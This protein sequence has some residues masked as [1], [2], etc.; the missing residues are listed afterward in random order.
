M[1]DWN[2]EQRQLRRAAQ[3]LGE[4]LSAGH[5]ER[6]GRAEFSRDGWKLVQRSGLLALPF[7][8]RWGG[9][10]QDLLTTMYVLEGLGHACRDSGLSFSLT[11]HVVSTGIPLQH[12]GS[13]E[14]QERFMP[15]VCAGDLIGA[16]AI[17]EPE[18][19]SDMLAL[20]TSAR[21]DGDELVLNGSKAFVTNGPVADVVVV[22]ARTD[23]AGGPFG[24]SAILVERDR[25]GLGFGRPVEKMGLR[26]SPLCEVFLDDC[27]VP[28]D[29]VI[30]GLGSGFLVFD[31]VMNWEVLCSFAVNVGEMQH[32]LER[33]VEYARSRKQ[34]G[35]HIGSFQAVAHRIVDMR[36][37]VDTARRALYDAAARVVRNEQATEDVAI[38]KLLVSE[39]NMATAV[40]AV[41]TFGGYG[42]M[43]ES[44]LEHDVRCAL[45]GLIYSGTSDIQRNRIAKMMGLHGAAPGC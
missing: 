45:A 44:G 40:A 7:D 25:E 27:R 43:T 35:S 10:G 15:A 3:R 16:H 4:S 21:V 14:L 37:A 42:Y 32:R 29:N 5:L 13:P 1:I 9:L 17:S 19:G 12:F 24:I 6:D 39:G 23:P 38:A 18:A 11:T 30:G 36:I 31:H 20:R 33:V 41:E 34:F 22:Y 2:D 8:H 26:T 28:T